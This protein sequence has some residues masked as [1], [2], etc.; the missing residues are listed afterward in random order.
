MT[1]A[2]EMASD[3]AYLDED[4]IK[5]VVDAS[6]A[7][8]RYGEERAKRLR[9][10]AATQ[11]I[12]ASLSEKYKHFQKDPWIEEAARAKDVKTMFPD[13]RCEMLI[14]GA[15][16]GGIQYATSMI[17]QAGISP[18]NLRIID[19]AGGF[20]GT[21]YYNRYPGL[22]CD[23]ESYLYLPFL[24][25]TGFIPKHRYSY[26]EEIRKYAEYIAEK[27]NFA[28]SAVF[29]TKAEKLTWIE[30]AKEWE[31]ELTQRIKGQPPV[32]I[33][34][35]STFVATV[36]GV[37]NWL[38][39]PDLPGLLDYKGDVFHI[40]RW[41]Y[42]ITGGSPDDPSLSRL[43]DKRVA[44]IGTGCSAVQAI[45]HLAKWSKH[46]YVVQRTPASVD[47]RDQ[48]PTYENE[49]RN[50]VATKPG[51]QR[52][53]LRNFHQH[54]TSGKKPDEDLVGDQWTQSIMLPISGNPEGPKAPEELPAYFQ[55]LQELDLPRQNSIRGRV[56]KTV[57]DADIAEKLQAWYPTWCKR[58]AF[59]DDYLDAFNKQNVTLLDT[60]GKDPEKI[61]ENSIQIDGKD[62]PVDIM[63]F[64]TGFRAPFSGT[65]AEK[66]NMAIIG[67]NGATM[68]ELWSR[69][70]PSTLHGVLDHNFPNLFLSGP[71]Q[72]S[73]SPNFLFNVGALSKHCAYI[74]T[75]AKQKAGGKPFAV[76]PSA[77]AAKNWG[78]QVLMRSLPMAAIIGCTPGYFNNEG[79][80][81]KVPPEFQPIMAKSGLW[82]SGIEDFVANIE[83]WRNEGSLQGVVVEV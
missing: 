71:W 18:K 12:E 11:F 17:E 70:G 10:D 41:N 25:E 47:R 2:V 38:K 44:I 43:Q 7:Q 73:T 57:K 69:N 53:R 28:D 26:G 81:D 36:N 55:K 33:T 15:G 30:N 24:E 60:N 64:A 67:R 3:R 83:A 23:I 63:I 48:K 79:E 20:G 13:N 72:S 56:T 6:E 68:T 34:I 27:Y 29:S 59:H 35:R 77:E 49:F 19:T 45:P 65:P 21:W 42:G 31:V 5:G 58:P 40:A 8:K 62:Y 51:W 9:A 75:Q 39:L 61:T 37:L 52:E 22:M 74:L 1:T 66:A 50:S 82:G 78:D 16:F 4:A 14:V 76:A 32:S 80:L 54:F 46:L